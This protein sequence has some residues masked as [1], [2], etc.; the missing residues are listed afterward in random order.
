[1][2]YLFVL[3]NAPELAFAEL[4]ALVQN[5]RLISLNL[6]TGDTDL[7]PKKLMQILGGTV[8]IAEI[9]AEDVKLTDVISGDFGISDLTGKINVTKLSKDIKNE[10]G[11]RFVLPKRGERQLSSVVV[12]KQK[13]TEI[14]I[15]EGWMGRTVA[16]QDFED[17]GKRDYGRP[18]AEGHIGMLPPKVARMM[19]NIG[20][21]TTDYR[22]QTVLDP[23]CGVGTI[24]A[25][26]MVLGLEVFGSDINENQIKKSK[27][28]LDW[29]SRTYNLEQGKF[30]LFV[31]D[32]NKISEKVK[33]VDAIVTEPVLGVN[34]RSGNI[35]EGH[36]LKLYVDCF[37]EWRKVLN[38]GGKVV[39]ALPGLRENTNLV[40]TVIDKVKLL[41]YS[42]Q[43][44]PYEYSR[45]QAIVR[46]NICI[47]IYG[48]Y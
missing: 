44:G 42:L 24:L 2:T 47:F 11:E 28:N 43:Q 20:L 22:L 32:A 38:T 45:P 34:D 16:V 14:I 36:L 35:N 18:E 48:A 25:E 37:S 1:M 15:G 33:G 23:F 31:H 46:R 17:W 27:N 12:A 41:G 8:K 29:L 5:T 4:N 9:L 7:D 6:A 30:K 21:P 26:G 10:T 13:L 40:K 39:I 19:V 3:G